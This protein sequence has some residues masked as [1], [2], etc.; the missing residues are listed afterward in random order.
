M[1]VTYSLYG[2]YGKLLKQLSATSP[3][4]DGT[5]KGKELNAGVFVWYVEVVYIDG[6][7]E[8]A[9]GNTTLLR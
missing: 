6:E 1:Y 8:I 5:F 7:E 3:G 4:W 2:K 9:K